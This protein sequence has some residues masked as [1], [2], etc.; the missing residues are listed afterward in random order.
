MELLENA[1]VA[2]TLALPARARW[3]V[4]ANS[5]EDV[6]E[7]T[8]WARTQRL[9]VLPLGSGSNVVLP[10]KIDAL[11]LKLG[12][13]GVAV[14]GDLVT[15]EAGEN[16]HGFVETSLKLG[17]YGLENLALIP[18]LVGA[19]PIQN[20]GAYGVEL[21]D[22]L[23][24]VDVFN[25]N[26]LEFVTLSR[27]DCSFSYRHSRFKTEPEWIVVGASLALSPVPNPVLDYPGICQYLEDHGLDPTPD[28]VLQAVIAIRR[29]KLPDPVWEPN[30]GSFFK[31]PVVSKEKAGA[32]AADYPALPQYPAGSEDSRKLSAAWLIEQSG[33]KG[34]VVGGFGVSAKHSLVITNQDDGRLAELEALMFHIQAE[35]T[36]RFG[37]RLEPEPGMVSRDGRVS[38]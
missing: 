9:E 35:V 34:Y 17:R 27:S 24:S 14:D 32:I 19:A 8:E 31:N 25:K 2:N 23:Y 37:V 22:W 16:W 29:A 15:V 20:I 33:L 38:L 11:V 21:Q 12:N 13:H 3:L 4:E 10:E 30:A 1:V 28:N 7:A 6:L 36:A 5:R 18:G 26:S